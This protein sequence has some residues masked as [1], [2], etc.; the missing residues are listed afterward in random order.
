[1]ARRRRG[2]GE[3]GIYQ[4]KDGLWV[5]SLSLGYDQNGKRRRRIV[6]GQTKAEVQEQLRKLQTDNALGRLPD[7][8]KFT[9]GDFLTLWLENT[10]RLKVQPT[11]YTRNEMKVR[12]HLVPHLGQVKLGKLTPPHVEHLYSAMEK[13]G[14]SP[15]ERQK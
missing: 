14:D 8:N 2:R 5:A 10:H 13:A 11:T 7:A 9:V 1:M 6:Y 3:G 4:R 15:Q 12:L